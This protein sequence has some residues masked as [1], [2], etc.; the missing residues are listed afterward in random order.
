MKSSLMDQLHEQK[1]ISL[2]IDVLSDVVRACFRSYASL[3]IRAWLLAHPSTPS[4]YL[5]SAHF[6]TTFHI[7]LGIPHPIVP[8]LS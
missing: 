5:Y 4:F 1:F 2:I 3:V 8:H 7:C 6:L